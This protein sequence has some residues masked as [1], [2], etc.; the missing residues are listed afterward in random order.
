MQGEI[1]RGRGMMPASRILV[2]AITL[3]LTTA[4][5]EASTGQFDYSIY[6][7]LMHSDNVGLSSTDPISQN[8]LIPGINFSYAQA[9]SAVQANAAGTL[10]YRDYLGNAFSSQTLAQL[11]SQVNWTILPQRLDFTV[12]DFAGV[13]PLSTLASNAPNNQ[14]QTNVLTLGPTLHFRVG[15]TMLGQA[16]LRYINSDASKTKEF[17]SSRGEAALRVFKDLSATTQVS[18]NLESQSV[19]FADP[20]AAAAAFYLPGALTTDPNYT[21][22]ELFGHYVSK[23]SQVDFDLALGWSQID[24]HS[25][26]STSTPLARLTVGWLATPSNHFQLSAVHQYSDAAED[27]ILQQPGQTLFGTDARQSNAFIAPLGINTGTSVIDSQVYLDRHVEGIY[28]YASERL[29]FS[30]SP[31]YGNSDYLNNPFFNQS[32]RSVSTAINY[33]LTP[34]T[35]VFGFGTEE[36]IT[37]RSLDRRDR[38]GDYGV[39][40]AR[41]ETPHWSWRVS[42]S[43]LRRSSSVP[44]NS[45]SENEI[46]VGIV[47]KR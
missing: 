32:D 41:Q 43:H 7:G 40:L 17:N 15:D 34:V 11:S 2:G 21:R 29:T 5:A 46:Y 39:G 19:V 33:R 28:S 44:D 38:T 36:S 45:Y 30:I 37:Y 3:A 14:Q 23:L 25:A 10:E 20:S 8:V 26:P 27:L 22:N 16:E 24:F 6:A 12:Q 9:G 13:Q 31:R 18:L 1:T 4:T 35:T 47:Y 42:L